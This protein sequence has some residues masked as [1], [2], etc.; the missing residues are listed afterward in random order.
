[1][2]RDVQAHLVILILPKAHS[3]TGYIYSNDRCKS[4]CIKPALFKTLTVVIFK[5]NGRVKFK[6]TDSRPSYLE[7]PV[8]IRMVGGSK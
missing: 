5:T 8:T 4:T 7:V 6:F 1:M 2:M 3:N